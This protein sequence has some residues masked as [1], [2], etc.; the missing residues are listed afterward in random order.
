MA[1]ALFRDAP[2]PIY[3]ITDGNRHEYGLTK[4]IGFAECAPETDVLA[5]LI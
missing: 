5:E 4:Q 1:Q 2:G 3:V